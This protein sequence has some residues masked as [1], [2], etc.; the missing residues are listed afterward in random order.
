MIFYKIDPSL[1]DLIWS[2]R[3]ELPDDVLQLIREY[4]K[5]WFKHFREYKSMLRL[6]AFGE[7]VA[8]RRAL[9]VKPEKV[10]PYIRAHEKTQTIWLEAYHDR[11]EKTREFYR[12]QDA[13]TRTFHDLIKIIKIDLSS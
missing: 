5:P 7:W 2:W 12:K 6:C 13:A 3:M 11:K 4:A 1:F 10:L 8:L 9:L